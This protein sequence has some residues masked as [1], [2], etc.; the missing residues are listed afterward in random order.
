MR[1]RTS[2]EQSTAAPRCPTPPPRSCSASG[3]WSAS[4]SGCGGPRHATLSVNAIPRCSPS[5]LEQRGLAG[6]LARMSA[7]RLTREFDR[8]EDA[9]AITQR[10]RDD[11]G[12]SDVLSEQIAYAGAKE[13]EEHGLLRDTSAED[14]PL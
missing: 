7:R 13:W 6:T 5:P 14:D 9:R 3:R 4:D 8:A 11:V 1:S 10:R 2:P 12:S